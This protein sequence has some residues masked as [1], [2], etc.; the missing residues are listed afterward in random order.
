MTSSLAVCVLSIQ[1]QTHNLRG[2]FVRWNSSSGV[3]SALPKSSAKA[4]QNNNALIKPV[5]YNRNPRNLE[6]LTISR[7]PEGYHLERF[8]VKYWHKLVLQVTQ[9]SVT[10]EVIH[11]NGTVVTSA[12]TSEFSIKRFLYRP[13]DHCAYKTVGKVIARRCLESG[14]NSIYCDIEA[15][16]DT[17]VGALFEEIQKGGLS[18]E[19]PECY[20]P[21]KPQSRQNPTKPWDIVP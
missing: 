20:T 7:K 11:N 13:K 16:E 17:K 4:E 9:S 19:E 8:N 5:F 1:K 2:L 6:L 14:I 18:L 21:L 10:A 12:S 3:A 15:Q